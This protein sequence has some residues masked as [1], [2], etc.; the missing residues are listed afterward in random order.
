ME[1]ETTNTNAIEAAAIEAIEPTETEAEIR[2][3]LSALMADMKEQIANSNSNE[4]TITKHDYVAPC[5]VIIAA[6][7]GNEADYLRRALAGDKPGDMDAKGL[8]AAGGRLAR[9]EQAVTI[10][11]KV[12]SLLI[13][14]GALSLKDESGAA[15][16]LRTN[17]VWEPIAT[18][19]AY[20]KVLAK[21]GALASQPMTFEALEESCAPE[22]GGKR[23]AAPRA[24]KSVELE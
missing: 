18:A 3:R 23:A 21:V 14:C 1:N 15:L 19:A 6:K 5:D 9:A 22:K 17:G 16:G 7:S 8:I 20:A 12:R 10:G 4:P 2:A 11:R 24:Q 13:A